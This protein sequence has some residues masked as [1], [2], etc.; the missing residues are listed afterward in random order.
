MIA[1][2]NLIR[3]RIQ[4]LLLACSLIITHYSDAQTFQGVYGTPL[5]N[6]FSKV[7]QDGNE[8]YVLG[9]D[10]PSAGA[11]SRATVSRLASDGTLLWTKSLG[12]SSQ[13]NDAIRVKKGDLM[14]VGNTLQLTDALG[15]SIMG[16]I[17]ANG[18]FAWVREYDEP[19]GR[20]FFLRIIENPNPENPNYPY[21]VMGSQKEVL[22]LSS[23]WDD[24]VIL[25]VNGNGNYNW[26]KIYVSDSDD[27]FFRS[28]VALANGNMIISGSRLNRQSDHSGIF[29]VTDNTGT[30]ISGKIANLMNYPDFTQAL[31]GSGFYTA[32]NSEIGKAPF[33]S[34]FGQSYSQ[35]WQVQL[36]TLVSISQIW[37]SSPGEI[38]ATGIGNFGSLSRTVI[39]KFHDNSPNAPNLIW[40]KYLNLGNGFLAGSS[41]LLPNNRMAFT[42]GRMVPNSFGGR[43]AFISITDL[44][45][46][47]CMTS[48]GIDT[49]VTTNLSPINQVLFPIVNIDTLGGA[50]IPNSFI[51]WNKKDPCQTCCADSSTFA[52]LINQ[53]FSISITK[54]KVT[55]T[56]PQ[57]DTCYLFSTPPSLDGAAVSQVITSPNGSWTFNFSQSGSHQICVNVFDECN[58]KKMC[59]SFNV[60]NCDTCVC[61]SFDLLYG[62]G[63]GPLVPVKCGE[64]LSVPSSIA[65]V[66]I[67]FISSFQ[68]LG[69]NCKQ[70]N[71]DYILTGPSG[72][73]PLSMS[74]IITNPDFI[75][76]ITNTSFTIAGLYT[77]TL[78]GHCGTNSCPC[79]IYF[80]ADGPSCCSSYID[81]CLSA[82]N[83]VNLIVDNNKCKVTLNIGNLPK[84]D[85][86]G[87]IF[88]G[89][90][91]SSSGPFSSG[92]MP[93]HNY[94]GNGNYY[95]TWTANEYDYSVNPPRPCFDKVFRDSIHLVCDT[96]QC[97]SFTNLSF[98]NPNWPGAFFP[99]SCGAMSIELPCLKQGQN[100]FLQGILNCNSLNCLRDSVQWNIS[101][102]GGPIIS[103][104]IT[105]I[106]SLNGQFNLSMNSN[107]FVSNSQYSLNISGHCG[108]TICTCKLNFSF[109]SCSC[110]CDSLTQEVAQGFFVSGKKSNCTRI[111]KPIDLCN[112]DKVSWSVTPSISPVPG[113]SIGNNSQVFNFSTPGIY[114]VCMSVTRIDPI[115]KDTCRAFYCRKVTVNCFPN[116]SLGLCEPNALNNGDFI[117]GRIE[118]YMGKSNTGRIENWNLFPNVGDGLVIVEDSSGA[119]DDGS[120]I[121]IG[122]KN[123]FA[124]I[125]Q[126]VDLN[127]E[128]FINIGFDFIV[129]RRN[130]LLNHLLAADI[131]IRLQNDSTLNASSSTEIL[132]KG[133]KE[134][135][136][137]RDKSYQRFDTSLSFQYNPELK[138]LVIC[139]QN[140]SENEYSNVGLDNIELCS[141]KLPLI[142][143]S[144]KIGAFR[145]YPNP[146]DEYI[147]VE[148]QQEF[149][150]G[151]T[152]QISDLTGRRIIEKQLLPGSFSQIIEVSSLSSGLYLVQLISNGKV[153]S[154]NKLIK[155]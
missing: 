130:G 147:T 138:Y 14:L 18:N 61:G 99:I 100:F 7:I 103:S 11:L 108:S 122:N 60:L 6:S 32:S 16:R 155:Q 77:L 17:D 84:C 12:I 83:A 50:N 145:F 96:C 85:S 152:I 95:I 125:W 4:A 27:E 25:N 106:N 22:G 98:I 56:A 29:Y 59:T 8:Y 76:P 142:T 126:Q 102:N 117:N 71:V 66:P 49:L 86:I 69:T 143:H 118:G 139:L 36:P 39:L 47:T 148:M 2:L 92:N 24:V 149:N 35:I 70:T 151:M 107:S 111:L 44:D 154:V 135:L 114:N 105:F 48:N 43:N 46:N 21:Y 68:C 91:S 13:W 144:E 133:M 52:T 45:M 129:Y 26:K 146:T 51:T 65:I 97:K 53:G 15:K 41:S 31:N 104:G 112:G 87:P 20:D 153:M 74:G 30:I 141:S 88:W 1:L 132:R 40:T 110:P 38:Y 123:N 79:T 33:I 34:K 37:E 63:R 72:F 10:Q 109:A 127:S 5:D 54:C 82:M 64:T 73:I 78:I 94:A 101:S 67:R 55:V 23:T 19:G 115:K 128:N 140:Q 119:F 124:G 42:D 58:S 81:F 137:D 57:F 131:V 134:K 28:V 75:V 121:L 89:D 136:E 3:S 9:Q 116:P 120:V 62:V 80:N 150:S 113:N 93:M 90:G